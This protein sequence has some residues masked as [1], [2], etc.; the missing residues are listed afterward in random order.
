MKAYIKEKM[1]RL[2]IDTFINDDIQTI[3]LEFVHDQ[4]ISRDLFFGEL[5]ILHYEMFNGKNIDIYSAAAA[6]EILI[7]AADILD[8]LQDIDNHSAPWQK[9][10]SS[11]VLNIT[12]GLLLLSKKILDD[13]NCSNRNL[14]D[15]IYYSTIFQAIT[16][17]HM[18]LHNS[19]NSEK[20]YLALIEKK[21]G[22]LTALACL[23]G[24][25][26][27]NSSALEEVRSYSKK[28]G[29]IAQI[30]NDIKSIYNFDKKSDIFLKKK[31]L[32]ILYML[33][34]RDNIVSEYYTSKK[35]YQELLMIKE[36]VIKQMCDRGAFHYAS[37]FIELNKQEA[38]AIIR[39]LN[40]SNF[41][42]KKLELY[43]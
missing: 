9:Y 35:T 41:Y 11:I 27:A 38:L 18:D 2:I 7:L 3:V 12:T 21:S 17:Q 28:I 8:D 1:D 13:L 10:E 40:I 14:L 22:S 30:N 31:T 16:G 24:A 20:Q 26:L 6:V 29:M 33:S 42:E 23:V 25:V 39:S 37:V 36:E 15:N 5:T 19:I 32:P 43:T 4:T 34:L